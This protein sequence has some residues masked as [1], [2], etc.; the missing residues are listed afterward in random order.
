MPAGKTQLQSLDLSRLPR[1]PPPRKVHPGPAGLLRVAS[2]KGHC[3]SAF[4]WGGLQGLV[5]PSSED[6]MRT[7]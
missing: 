4:H 5:F 7:S 3:I 2:D 1:R 6:H